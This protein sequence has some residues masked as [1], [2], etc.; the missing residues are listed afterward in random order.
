MAK[1]IGFAVVGLGTVARTSVLPAF[2]A[3]GGNSRLVAVVS[4]DR[5]KAQIVARE[6][7]AAAYHYDELRQSLQRE[8]VNAVYIALP[9]SLHC[10]YAV[11]AARAGVHVLC[12]PPMAITA[13]ECRRMIRTC[14]TNR[15]KLMIAYRLHVRP[16][17][18]RALGLVRAG[19]VGIPKTFSAD[20]TTRIEDPENTRLQRRLGGGTVYHL[21]VECIHAARS[22]LGAEPAQ[23][24][25]MTARTSRRY[26]GDVDESAVALIRFPDERLAHFHSSFGEEGSIHVLNAF[27]PTLPS[28]LVTVKRGE[29]QEQTFEPTDEYAAVLAYFADAIRED[30]QPEPSGIEGLQDTRLI[31]AIYRSS[32]DGRPVTL[33]RLARVEPSPVDNDV[34]RASIEG[35]QAG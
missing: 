2:A 14:Q 6:F 34:R 31:E 10:D 30:R 28:H 11:E 32:R 24:M 25:A 8:D 27:T 15:V 12:E 19:H 16:A 1:Q 17:V 33:P 3:I 21:G 22:V 29:R 20:F 4:G 5:T 13:D 35:R 7:K 23:V 26:G 9:N 18:V